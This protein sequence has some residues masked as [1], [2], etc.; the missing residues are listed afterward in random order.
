MIII[1]QQKKEV[2]SLSKEI[3][4]IGGIEL[5]AGDWWLAL[6]ITLGIFNFIMI[7]LMMDLICHL[8]HIGGKKT[9]QPMMD[10]AVCIAKRVMCFVCPTS[11]DIT[12]SADK[13]YEEQ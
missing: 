13:D 5:E 9:R 3:C 4:N 2:R 6:N 8:T 10:R 7:I 12:T 1:S 11:T